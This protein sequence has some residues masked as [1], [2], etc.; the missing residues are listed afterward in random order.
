MK[1][2]FTEKKEVG[3]QIA[4]VLYNIKED[5]GKEFN[6]S[7]ESIKSKEAKKGYIQGSNYIITWAS[8]HLMRDTQPQDI[9]EAYQFEFKFN[10]Q[11]DYKM[12]NLLNEKTS[13]TKGVDSNK[14]QQIKVIKEL[15]SKNKFDEII[16][17]TD[18]DAEGEAIARDA[19]FKIA[20]VNPKNTKITRFWITGSF[21]AEDTIKKAL[22]TRESYDVAKYNNL[23]D[24]RVGRADCDYL[25]GL[26]PKKALVDMY[27]TMIVT[28]RV[29]SVII[30]LVGDRELEIKNFKPKE[31]Y[32]IKGFI[33][34]LKLSNFYIEDVDDVDANGKL[35][36]KKEKTTSYYDKQAKDEVI[37]QT[38]ERAGTISKL[39]VKKNQVSG[40][41]NRPLPLSG[42]DFKSIMMDKHKIN[43]KQAGE[44]L[45]YLRDE[46]FTTYQG[47]NGRYFSLADSD[48][49]HTAYNTAKSYFSKD[50]KANPYHT[51]VAFFDD[52][53]AA[54]QNHPPLHLTQKIP[55]ASDFTKWE[56]SK[57]PKVKEG[58]ELIA[59]RIF[60]HFLED[61]LFDSVKIEV[62]IKGNLFE[63][64]GERPIKHGW[65]E[66]VGMKKTDTFFDIGTKKIGDS[67]TLDKIEQETLLTKVPK[68]Y[69][70]KTLLS[71]LMNIGSVIQE[72]INNTDSPDEKLLYKKAKA[73]LKQAE[74][75]GTDRTRETIIAEL[76]SGKSKAVDMAKNSNL[77]LNELGWKSHKVLP[78]KFKSFLVTAEWEEALES[79]RNGKLKVD[80]FIK[81]INKDIENTIE[82]FIKNKDESLV[83]QRTVRTPSVKEAT[84]MKCPLCQSYIIKDAMVYK[85][86]TQKYSNGK[87]S[88]C[89][90][91]VFKQNKL[92]GEITDELMQELLEK[93]K[94]TFNGKEL[95]L[96]LNSKY[97][98]EVIFGE[99]NQESKPQQASPN[100][101]ELK[102]G[103][104]LDR[105]RYYLKDKFVY[106][107]VLGS[108]VLKEA[109][110]KKL[111]N[112]EV[113]ELKGCISKAGK[114]Y[115]AKVTLNASGGVDFAN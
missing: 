43:L 84:S 3:C 62:D 8:G 42:D 87:V 69:T 45:Q 66:F 13:T 71:A 4:S 113:V 40:N 91:A 46:G 64:S 57:I 106:E 12:P 5:S 52:K 28:G 21:K 101:K 81:G 68:L 29:K 24:S 112:G 9:N 86:E 110:A 26:K 100:S 77:T 54:L 10:P 73:T 74:G 25:V 104:T 49:V 107:K 35:I 102:N 47:T 17:S 97:Y 98:I 103:L 27:S 20:K 83:E 92:I 16:I 95:K 33:D 15:F 105:G 19:L 63:A 55:T 30:G 6:S 108:R 85:C 93:Q 31:Y 72:K 78:T 82:S 41:K 34:N 65:R 32:Q 96:N 14:L 37:K 1:L 44:I 111:L 53:K 7:W 36:T 90:F 114:K 59:K 38:K 61:D 109:E 48:D 76:T 58:Y 80:D 89:P 56:S 39:E 70:E 88:G 22:Q 2:I 75:I 50:V 115:D 79:I 67:I 94:A 51:D 60:V 99:K 11:F 18:A 23:Y